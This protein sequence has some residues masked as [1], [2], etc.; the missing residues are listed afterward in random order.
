MSLTNNKIE[1]VEVTDTT[2]KSAIEQQGKT[3]QS[4]CLFDRPS[5]WYS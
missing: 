1:I 4:D 3:S 5:H 2:K